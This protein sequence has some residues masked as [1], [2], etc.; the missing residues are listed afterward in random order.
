[1]PNGN[2][3]LINKN[4]YITNNINNNMNNN[5]KNIYNKRRKSINNINYQNNIFSSIILILMTIKI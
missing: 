1:M 2:I 5:F 4:K 3:I